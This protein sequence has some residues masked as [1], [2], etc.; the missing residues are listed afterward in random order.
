MLRSLCFGTRSST[1]LR[2]TRLDFAA[3]SIGGLALA[4][5]A[6]LGLAGLWSLCIDTPYR[7]VQDSAWLRLDYFF[8]SGN[9]LII[10][11]FGIPIFRKRRNSALSL[12]S[13]RD[14]MMILLS[15]ELSVC[16]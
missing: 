5:Q 13:S 11:A 2:S 4:S 7:A 14:S 9:A 10:G 3:L 8:A 1:P 12:A 16:R 15:R 6:Q